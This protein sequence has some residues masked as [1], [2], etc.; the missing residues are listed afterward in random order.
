[1]ASRLAAIVESSADAIIG[2]TLDGTITS[3]NAG[4]QHMY[5]YAAAEVVGHNVSVIIPPDQA[6]ELEMILGR[7]RRGDR[8]EHFETKRRCKDGR[9]LDVSVSISPIRDAGGGRGVDRGAGH[10]RAEPGRG[11][12]ACHSAGAASV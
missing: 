10:D 6:D 5:G 9:V 8:I 7:L 4:A 2:K 12:A 1:M 11:G 3:W